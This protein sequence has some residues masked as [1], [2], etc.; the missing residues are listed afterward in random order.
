MTKLKLLRRGGLGLVTLAFVAA[1]AAG[2]TAFE[3]HVINVTAAIENALNVPIKAIDFGTVFPQE[4]LDKQFDVSLSSSFLSENRVDDVDYFLRQKPKCGVPIANTSPV[5]YSEFVQ[6]GEDAQGNFVCPQG[7][8]ALPLLC[9]YLSKH[10]L[11]ADGGDIAAP[12]ENDGPG[13]LAFHGPIALADWTMGVAKQ[14]DVQGRMAK[15]EQDTSDTWDIDLKVPCFGGHCAQDWSSF[16][17][18]INPSSTPASYIQPLQY[19]HELYGC[20]LWLE[21]KGISLTPQNGTLIIQKVV[22]NDSQTGSSTAPDFS[23]TVNGG[24]STQFEA[25]GENEMS[26]PPG[27]YDVVENAASGYNTT[28]QNCSGLDIQAGET[29]VCVITNDD[30]VAPAGLIVHKVV[31]NDNGGNNAAGDFQLT[32][33]GN[34]V[35]QSATT[36]FSAGVHVVSESGV[37]GYVAAFSGDCDSSGNVSLVS[38]QTKTCTV[39]NN[40]LPGNITLIKSVINDNGGTANPTSF[41]LRIDGG[42]VPNNTS[43]AVTA[44]SAHSINEDAKAGYSFVSLTGAGCPAV[45]GGTVTLNEGEAVTC[46]ISNNDNAPQALT[47]FPD[48]FGTGS[49]LSDIPNWD[50]HEDGTIAQSPSV[51]GE[52]TASPDAGRFAKIAEDSGDAGSVDGWICRSV[53]ATGLNS[54]VL[55]YQWRGDADAENTDLGLVQYFTGGTCASPTGGPNA[56]ASHDLSNDAAWSSSSVNL[57]S[58]LNGTTFLI[59]FYNNSSADDEYFRV[60]A[61]SLTGVPN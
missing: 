25:D 44:N 19:E 49:S 29:Q 1:G 57:P 43:V 50:E 12:A 54:L 18:G 15:S 59:R 17:L 34:N 58:G 52:D 2:L 14:Y 37:S 28:Y 31:V 8:V 32:V 3:A 60:D 47:G 26:V 6:V 39:T 4:K 55:A 16:V 61:V 53:N 36:T 33:D 45:L 46:T 51:S 13:I 5:E 48:N 23:F 10:E 24:A 38:G 9:P 40:D 21:V 11:T 42:V 7:S 30:I 56:L 22:I 35:A 41:T 20:D 27:S